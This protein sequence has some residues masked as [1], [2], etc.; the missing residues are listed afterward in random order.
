MVVWVC[1]AKQKGKT[2]NEIFKQHCLKDSFE[3]YFNHIKEEGNGILDVTHTVHKYLD[4]K[5]LA[6]SLCSDDERQ[7]LN[8]YI[9]DIEGKEK[10]R[11]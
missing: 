5:H 3:F 11:K 6:R 10:N 4:F 2:L 1:K 8:K 7:E 9:E